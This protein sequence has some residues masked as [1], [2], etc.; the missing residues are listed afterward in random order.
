MF[1]VYCEGHGHDVLLQPGR[2]SLHNVE[3]RIVVAWRCRC[4]TEGAFVTGR[5]RVVQAA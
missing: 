2:F 1:S 3:G 4:G 5:G